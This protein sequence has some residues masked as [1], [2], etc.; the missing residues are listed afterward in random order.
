MSKHFCIRRITTSS[1]SSKIKTV[2]HRQQ[3]QQ[4]KLRVKKYFCT[5]I[6]LSLFF[7][8]FIEHFFPSSKNVLKINSDEFQLAL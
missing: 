3:Q 2:S 7:L 8:S 5:I 6:N 4:Q 1:L